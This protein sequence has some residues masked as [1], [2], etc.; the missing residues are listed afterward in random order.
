MLRRV[1]L[2]MMV[3]L[4]FLGRVVPASAQGS[5]E[6]CGAESYEDFASLA[7]ALAR[8]AAG[9]QYAY[10]QDRIRLNDD[11]S[12]NLGVYADS[13]AGDATGLRF[14][15]FYIG[16]ERA[17]AATDVPTRLTIQ[18]PPGD[19]T[20][21]AGGSANLRSGPA[22][23]SD[24]VGAT[25]AGQVFP[26]IAAVTRSGFNWLNVQTS[27]GEAWLRS[28]LVRVSN[29]DALAG[30]RPQFVFDFND[31]VPYADA[32]RAAGCP[33]PSAVL[34]QTPPNTTI[35]YDVNGLTLLQNG[36]A[37]IMQENFAQA[38][39][40]V[41]GGRRRVYFT[42]LQGTLE[43]VA[44]LTPFQLTDA[45]RT[46]AVEFDEEGMPQ[47][48]TG[49]FT[50]AEQELATS[51]WRFVCETA[52][53][54]NRALFGATE[55]GFLYAD[56][57]CT[58]TF[59]SLHPGWH[60]VL[61]GAASA[62]SAPITAVGDVEASPP[63]PTPAPP[64]TEPIIVTDA[65]VDPVDCDTFQPATGSVIFWNLKGLDA[66]PVADGVRLTANLEGGENIPGTRYVYFRVQAGEEPAR[67]YAVQ[68]EGNTAIE[69][70]ERTQGF[71]L[72]PG[73]ENAMQIEPPNRVSVLVNAGE[74]SAFVVSGVVDGACDKSPDDGFEDESATW[75]RYA[76]ETG[77]SPSG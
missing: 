52:N 19:V 1:F 67:L 34:V 43:T 60:A 8:D 7:G 26:V 48:Y 37:I 46:F 64:Q 5:I 70:G 40:Y 38:A 65:D 10:L 50:Q 73:T 17:S 39:G 77:F 24:L 59:V 6:D 71:Q 45:D 66:E 49:S 75:L 16:T 30:L 53:L 4:I 72:I 13:F 56:A 3:A 63:E 9:G 54:Y 33:L 68:L 76:S 55:S 15:A 62:L 32:E 74:F 23:A 20:A 47:G 41:G 14:T 25:R 22:T 35:A 61:D 57:P 12:L 27:E 58:G 29:R 31:L 44:P 42:N 18:A 11:F 21:T 28:D 51:A 36:T 2:W 69:A